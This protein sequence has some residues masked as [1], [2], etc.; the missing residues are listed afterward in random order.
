MLK[1]RSAVRI[2]VM[3]GRA[4]RIIARIIFVICGL[5]SLLT[6]VPYVLLRGVDLPVQSEWVIFAVILGIVGVS[7][8]AAGVLPRGWI[9]KVCHRDRDDPSLFSAPLKLLGG[10]AGIFYLAAVV[11]DLAPHRW[12]LDPQ[13][14]LA[15]CPLYF[16]KMNVDPSLVEVFYLLAPMNAAV[17][18]AVGLVVAVGIVRLRGTSRS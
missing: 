4:V 5:G 12:D 8:L 17:Y 11:A 9:A 3:S 14:M 10:F 6:G 18:G 16:L 1:L 2:R 7:S 15:V 13:L